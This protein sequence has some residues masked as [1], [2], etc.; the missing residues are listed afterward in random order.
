MGPLA[1]SLF[2][3]DGFLGFIMG[4]PSAFS[5]APG[6]LSTKLSGVL[7]RLIQGESSGGSMSLP[8][9]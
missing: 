1:P 4:C 3:Q 6:F 8:Y 2:Q 5:I 9:V 7:I